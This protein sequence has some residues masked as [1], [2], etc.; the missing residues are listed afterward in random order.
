MKEINVVLLRIIQ[1]GITMRK[2]MIILTDT[3]KETL[4]RIHLLSESEEI[5]DMVKNV[6]QCDNDPLPIIDLDQ[7]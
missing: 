3:Q 4:Q 6:M 5:K 2:L 1:K 7:E